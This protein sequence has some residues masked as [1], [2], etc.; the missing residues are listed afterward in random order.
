LR[1]RVK[2]LGIFRDRTPPGNV[3]DLPEGATL[4]QALEALNISPNHVHLT[5]VNEE[6]QRDPSRVLQ[7]GDE[8]MVMPPVAGG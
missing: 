2:L 4:G 6:H 1:I 7:E 8:L 5:M 3:L